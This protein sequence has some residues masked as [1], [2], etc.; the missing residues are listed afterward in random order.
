MSVHRHAVLCRRRP[1]ALLAALVASA[2]LTASA[3]AAPPVQVHFKIEDTFPSEV[4]GIPITERVSGFIN[5]TT[6]PS[7]TG[8]GDFR[9]TSNFVLTFTNPETGRSVGL[10]FPGRGSGTSVENPDGTTTFTSVRSGPDVVF[11]ARRGEILARDT[12]RLILETV[13]DLNDPGDPSDD[14]VVGQSV[15]FQA[16][17]HPQSDGDIDFCAIVVP[18]LT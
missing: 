6:F 9:D 1:V 3:A 11:G 13:I 7:A 17:P 2:L 5:I 12:G 15:V 4:C 8:H 16:G 18:A 14:V 10:T